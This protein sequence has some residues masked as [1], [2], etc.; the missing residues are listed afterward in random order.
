VV[1]GADPLNLTGE[2]LGG[3]R[4]PAVRHRSVRYRNGTPDNAAPADGELTRA[5][6]DEVA[7]PGEVELAARL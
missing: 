1:A 2:W 3:A 4:V 7:T 6:P 5:A